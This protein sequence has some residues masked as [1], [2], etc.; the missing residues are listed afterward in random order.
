MYGSSLPDAFLNAD[1]ANK[2][3]GLSLTPGGVVWVVLL[4]L[5]L[6]GY[7]R[8]GFVSQLEFSRSGASRAKAI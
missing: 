5:V 1:A 2:S 4:L 8:E 3:R 7:L 6:V